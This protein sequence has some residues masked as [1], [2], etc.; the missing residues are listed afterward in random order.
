MTHTKQ[1][2]DTDTEEAETLNLMKILISY[3][4]YVQEIKKIV[5]KDLKGNMRKMSPQIVSID[6]FRK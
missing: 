3:F 6:Y 4:K 1:S 5:S 2:K